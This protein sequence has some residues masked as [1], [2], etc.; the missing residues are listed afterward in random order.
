MNHAF[1]LRGAPRSL[2]GRILWLILGSVLLVLA[3]MFSLI[4]LAA[5]ASVGSVFAARWWWKTRA[6][7]KLWREMKAAAQAASGPASAA[8]Q[9]DAASPR[10]PGDFI[11]GE[12]VREPDGLNGRRLGPQLH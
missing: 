6:L 5:I 3:A 1:L 11:D 12:F 9:A 7:R 2:G 8:K 4:V 10:E